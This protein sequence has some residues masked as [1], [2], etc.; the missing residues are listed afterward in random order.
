MEVNDFEYPRVYCICICLRE[1]H[2]I[3]D[4]QLDFSF[5]YTMLSGKVPFQP[6]Q[7]TNQSAI[8]IMKSIMQGEVSFN[9]EEWR[10][11]SLSA[12]GLIQGMLL[13]R[14]QQ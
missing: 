9:G 7:Y 12:K 14:C 10:D 8:G 13:I 4:N 1:I 11:V 5:Q 2:T 3:I 6:K